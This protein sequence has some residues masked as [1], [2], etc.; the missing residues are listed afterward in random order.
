M[1][2]VIK[3]HKESL[4]WDEEDDIELQNDV[5]SSIPKPRHTESARKVCSDFRKWL[6]IRYQNAAAH[7]S[8][9]GDLCVCVCVCVCVWKN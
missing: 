9:A 2:T 6:S 5:V 3:H 4:H 7:V 1:L 8:D